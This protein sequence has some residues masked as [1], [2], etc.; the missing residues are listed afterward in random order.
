MAGAAELVQACPDVTFILQ[1]AGMLED[2]SDEGWQEWREGMKALAK[3][4]NIVTKLSGFGTFIHKND[5]DHIAKMIA[6]TVKIFGA[7]RCL[8]G[9]NFPIE[10]IWTNYDALVDAFIAG[11]KNLSQKKQKAIFYETA[12]R[13]YRL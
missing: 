8:F 7:E 9:S 3:Q 6:E 13:V 4:P 11:T 10:K 12:Q 1:H 5:P 2:L